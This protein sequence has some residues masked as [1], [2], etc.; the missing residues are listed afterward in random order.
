[1]LS[2]E[3]L[4][5]SRCGLVRADVPR[6]TGTSASCTPDLSMTRKY[7]LRSI[8]REAGLL[9][10]LF[11]LMLLV[12]SRHHKDWVNLRFMLATHSL[13]LT[14]PLETDV[15]RPTL[16]GSGGRM[17]FQVVEVREQGNGEVCPPQRQ[18]LWFSMTIYGTSIVFAMNYCP[19]YSEE[20][21]SIREK[22]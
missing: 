20:D 22:G 2:Q 10:G 17:L 13:L 15:L 5:F 18:L 14:G 16:A 6:I 19:M 12:Q 3:G 8:A 1:M 4:C 21:N 7:V 11:T 9:R